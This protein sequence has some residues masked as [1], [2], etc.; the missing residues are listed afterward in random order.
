MYR[1]GRGEE[2][3]LST[4]PYTSRLVALWRFRTAAEA[5][6]SVAAL[7]QRF[8][9]YRDDGD[10]AGMDMVRK[11]LQMGVTRSRRYARHRSGRKYGPDRLELPL[12]PDPEK[13]RSALIFDV[14]WRRVRTDPVYLEAKER[15]KAAVQARKRRSKP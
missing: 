1:I 13:E 7:L 12:D 9:E 15:H 5:R 6:K 3:V 4:E 2:G 10:F 11:F 8:K 14:A